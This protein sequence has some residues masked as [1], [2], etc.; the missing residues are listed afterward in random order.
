MTALD[1][2]FRLADFKLLLPLRRD[3][4]TLVINAADTRFLA[5]LANE[6]GE[7]HVVSSASAQV[8]QPD[9]LYE[10]VFSDS[11]DATSYLSPGGT[12]CHLAPASTANHTSRTDGLTLIG[13]WRAFPSWPNFRVLI[14]DHPLGW[15]AAI[16][17]LRLLPLRSLLGVIA[18]VLPT[19]AARAL[20][21]HGIALYRQEFADQAAPACL[22]ENLNTALQTAAGR[23]A[24][25]HDFAPVKWIPVSGQLGPGN[26]MLAFR[27]DNSG[28]LRELIKVARYPD[29]DH[30]L[31]EAEKLQLINKTLGPTLAAKVILPT[32]AACV[33]GRHALAYDYVPTFTFFGLRWSLQARRGFCLAMTDWLADMALSTRRDDAPDVAEALHCAPLRQLIDR[34]ILPA[35]M[36]ADARRALSWLATQVSLPTVFEH[37]DLGIY[38]TRMISADG[39]DFK[40]LDWGS[41]TFEG[42]ALGDL[43]YLLSSARAS[44]ALAAAC[45]QRYLQRLQLSTDAA[46]PLW[47]AYL[48]RRWAELDSVRTPVA[49]D[50]RSGGGVLLA[51]HNQVL[52]SLQRLTA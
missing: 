36:Q 47:F 23:A 26:P 32:A 45:L 44:T 49:N 37:G 25:N 34:N 7:I 3:Q 22:L 2:D 40:V 16:R 41:S 15:R 13:A 35:V 1:N 12:L 38:N 6:L 14:P 11:M 21:H 19:I 46:A 20:P 18:R 24:G 52:P 29:A 51:I 30:L 31:L 27:M 43:A 4:R 28:S 8:Q 10:L 33:D 39:S 17:G 5:H 48:A 9:G 42:I 50:P